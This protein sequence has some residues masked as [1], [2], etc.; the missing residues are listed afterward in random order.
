MTASNGGWLSATVS[1]ISYMSRVTTH[2]KHAPSMNFSSRQTKSVVCFVAVITGI[3]CLLKAYLV[4]SALKRADG[5]SSANTF[6]D[7]LTCKVAYAQHL[8]ML[9]CLTVLNFATGF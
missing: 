3:S 8:C 6:F 2:G 4:L 7:E 1:T 5:V 9:L